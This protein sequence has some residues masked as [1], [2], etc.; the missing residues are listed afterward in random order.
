MANDAKQDDSPIAFRLA[1]PHMTSLKQ[2]ATQA[3]TS[4]SK[5]A[6]ALLILAI[7]QQPAWEEIKAIRSD[8]HD[9]RT[10]LARSVECLLMNSATELT[11]EEVASWVFDKLWPEAK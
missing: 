5:M 1:E 7:E 6:R 3:D 11:R 8:V 2:L 9:L 4:P 10:A